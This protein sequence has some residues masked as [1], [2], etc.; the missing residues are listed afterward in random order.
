MKL[1]KSNGKHNISITTGTITALDI[2]Y[3]FHQI[4]S[5]AAIK[6]IE[7]VFGKCKKELLL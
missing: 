7:N 5:K 4:T 1:I 6:K 3:L 2:M